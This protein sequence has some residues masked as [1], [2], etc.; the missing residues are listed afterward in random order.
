MCFATDRVIPAGAPDLKLFTPSYV[1]ELLQQNSSESRMK[2]LAFTDLDLNYLL[3]F[4]FVN[5][6]ISE[7]EGCRIL[8]LQDGKLWKFQDESESTDVCYFINQEG[9]DIFKDIASGCLICPAVLQW[10]IAIRLK[11]TRTC[12]VQRFDASVVDRLLRKSP[13]SPGLIE[14]Y[15][16]EKSER[17]SSVYSYV[18]SRGLRSRRFRIIQ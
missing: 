12:N 17:V 3:K 15:S 16:E 18:S 5:Q 8:R 1:R 14:T 13:L 2:E 11:I 10:D 4:I 6:R 9:F 7:S